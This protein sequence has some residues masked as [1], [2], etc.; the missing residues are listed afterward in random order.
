MGIKWNILSHFNKINFK[1]VLP[2]VLFAG[3]KVC[4]QFAVSLNVVL[5]I[6]KTR[7]N[8]NCKIMS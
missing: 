3:A 4:P 1:A 6:F 5:L 2:F 8:E 7:L